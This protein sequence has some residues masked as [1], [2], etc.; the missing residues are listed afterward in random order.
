MKVVKSVLLCLLA[1]VIVINPVFALDEENL[2]RFSANNIMFY[3]PDVCNTKKTNS[4][5]SGVTAE[6]GGYER[7]KQAIETYYETAME[8]QVEWGTPWDVVFAQ[9]Q[10]ESQVGTTGVAVSGADNNWLG[11][12][13]TGDAGKYGRF[14][15]FSSVEKSIEAW[16]GTHVLRNG[17]YDDAF[18]YLNINNWDMHSFLTTMISHYAP[19]SDGNNEEAYVSSIEAL[20]NG[21]IKEKQEEM[22]LPSS[23]EYAKQENIPVGGKH[24]LDSTDTGSTSTTSTVTANCPDENATIDGKYLAKKAVDM[25]WPIQEDG[26]CETSSGNSVSWSTN[27]SDCYSNPRDL[28]QEN[29]N[30]YNMVGSLLDCGHFVAT[31]VHSAEVDEDFPKSGTTYQGTHLEGSSKWKKVSAS[32]E[33]DLEPGDIMWYHGHI[34][35][36]VGEYGGD[37]GKIASASQN[38]YVGI[39]KNFRIQR[40]GETATVYRLIP[41]TAGLKSGGMTLEEAEAFMEAY[42]EES[43]KFK[44]GDY[45]FQDALVTDAGC[46]SGTLNNCSAF[47]QWFLNKYTEFGPSGATR[48]QGSIAVSNYLND[49]SKLENGGKVP[50]VYAI[51]SQGPL[52]GSSGGWGNHTAIVLGINTDSDEIIFGEASCG[53]SKGE[54]SYR[55][56]AHAYSLSQYTNS[57][58]TYG[59]TYAYTDN[60]LKLNGN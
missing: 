60:I 9:M 39:I 6:G 32:S 58:D 29:Y 20:L 49:N 26:T 15:I 48:W 11:I 14:A 18:P 42:A 2:D 8:M 59:P 46:P 36:Y 5:S 24:P 10:H 13:G 1:S 17:Y 53:M 28:Y 55:P 37:Y 43:D 4:S 33:S 30:K 54:R 38:D 44:T 19:S 35:M 57:P 23:F 40:K 50:K 12:T 3:D 41:Q 16:A 21:P 52:T 47:T 27:A 31:V 51:M 56:R 25:A 22:G 7:L 34:E 45:Y